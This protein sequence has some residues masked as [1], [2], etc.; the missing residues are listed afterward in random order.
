MCPDGV[1]LPAEAAHSIQV[2]DEQIIFSG[3]INKRTLKYLPGLNLPI[4][5]EQRM[6]SLMKEIQHRSQTSLNS[7][8]IHRFY[9]PSK[10]QSTKDRAVN[11]AKNA[12]P[13]GTFYTFLPSLLAWPT[14]PC[15]WPLPSQPHTLHLHLPS[16]MTYGVKVNTKVTS[17]RMS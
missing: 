5:V 1:S 8:S 7:H 6:W 9:G 11:K 2:S 12:H 14:G 3:K 10:S 16:F 15:P 17:V 4:Y 13:H